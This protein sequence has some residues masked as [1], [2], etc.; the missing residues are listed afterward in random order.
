[1]FRGRYWV[2]L[3]VVVADQFAHGRGHLLNY[4]S[5]FNEQWWTRGRRSTA[6]VSCQR[7]GTGPFDMAR[8]PVS[9]CM[10]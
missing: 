7:G 2:G 5:D 9:R 10:S 4:S 3:E 1:M 8:L 6:A